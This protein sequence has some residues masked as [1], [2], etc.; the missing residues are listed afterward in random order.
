MRSLTVHQL[1]KASPPLE[2]TVYGLPYEISAIVAAQETNGACQIAQLAAVAEG[3]GT[4]LSAIAT[5]TTINDV[6]DALGVPQTFVPVW[7]QLL[8]ESAESP[9]AGGQ[10]PRLP[11]ETLFALGRWGEPFP[12]DPEVVAGLRD[13]GLIQPPAPLPGRFDELEHLA[14]MFEQG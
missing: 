8:G 4:C 9:E 11:F 6:R 7:L 2:Q 5:P 1:P 10:R 12:R 14:R 3:L 13:D